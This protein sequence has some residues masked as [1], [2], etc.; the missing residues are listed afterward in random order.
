M[1]LHH[2]SVDDLLPTLLHEVMHH[3]LFKLEGWSATSAWDNL[4][5]N[6]GANWHFFAPHIADLEAEAS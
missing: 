5:P 4:V 1:I 3:V 2:V 6:A